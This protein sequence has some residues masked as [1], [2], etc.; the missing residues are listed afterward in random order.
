MKKLPHPY[1][2]LVFLTGLNLFN[3]MDRYVLASIVPPLKADLMLSDTQIGWLTSAFMIG[4]FATAPVFGYLGDRWR[5]KGLIAF[6]VTF[7]SLGTILAASARD[8]G[9]CSRAACWWGWER[10]VMRCWRLRGFATF[11]AQ[12]SA[13]TP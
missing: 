11:S 4:Y 8:I 10:R 13:I 12:S 6:G 3:Y 1:L 5:R 9:C 7:W 2:G